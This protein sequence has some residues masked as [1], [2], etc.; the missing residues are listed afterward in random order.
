MPRGCWGAGLG[1]A[2]GGGAS[3]LVP[4][5]AGD[6]LAAFP[7]GSSR[8]ERAQQDRGQ[9]VTARHKYIYMYLETSL[10]AAQTVSPKH[11]IITSP[12]EQN[13]SCSRHP[14]QTALGN[15]LCLPAAPLPR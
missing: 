7:R 13:K 2:A 14:P 12:K 1:G 15:C 9:I 4:G 11:L 3:L 6:R 10:Y 8:Q 5:A